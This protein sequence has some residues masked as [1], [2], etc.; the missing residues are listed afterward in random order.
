MV[1]VTSR[2]RSKRRAI[3]NGTT[4]WCINVAKVLVDNPPDFLDLLEKRV[5]MSA[6]KADV[7]E[8]CAAQFKICFKS[9]G[10]AIIKLC[11]GVFTSSEPDGDWDKSL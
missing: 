2:A 1:K 5:Q 7:C 4:V 11:E 3:A 9:D 8:P 10:G 6:R